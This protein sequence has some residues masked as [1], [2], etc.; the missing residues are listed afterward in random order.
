MNDIIKTI[1][2]FENGLLTSGLNADNVDYDA[3]SGVRTK[4]WN[5]LAELIAP[6]ICICAAVKD[7]DGNVWRGHRHGDCMVTIMAANR[8]IGQRTDDQ[9]F[10]TS[11]NRFVTRTEGRKL[12][13]AAGIQS[14][15]IEDGGY[16]GDTLF[17]EDLY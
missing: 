9:G 10:V 14:A 5:K 8:L 6:E 17:S 4:C 15:A 2:E 12:Q 13:D 11:K 3:L 7:A 16:R 1:E